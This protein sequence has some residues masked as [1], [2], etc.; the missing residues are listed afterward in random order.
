[1]NKEVEDARKTISDALK[2]DIAMLLYKHG[3]S[4]LTRDKVASEI[5]TLIFD[6]N[7]KL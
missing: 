3:C 1:M 5:I 6:N 7:P 2:E 4:K